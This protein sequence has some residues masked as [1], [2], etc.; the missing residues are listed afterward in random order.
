MRMSPITRC[1]THAL[2]ANGSALLPHMCERVAGAHGFDVKD[3][4]QFFMRGCLW[5][6]PI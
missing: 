3:E 1:L 4:G 5:D 6:C 2:V